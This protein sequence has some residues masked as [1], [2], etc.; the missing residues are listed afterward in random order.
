MNRTPKAAARGFFLDLALGYRAWRRAAEAAPPKPKSERRSI[1]AR[2]AARTKARNKA[3]ADDAHGR[4]MP[5][6]Q[7][8][9]WVALNIWGPS[10]RK[11]R[12]RLLSRMWTRAGHDPGIFRECVRVY[13][14][15]LAEDMDALD[16]DRKYVNSKADLAWVEYVEAAMGAPDAK[17]CEVALATINQGGTRLKDFPALHYVRA[18]SG[19]YKNGVVHVRRGK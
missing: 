9:L 3:A 19:S 16:D 15:A 6:V 18:P 8:D 14:G 13:L 2:K 7:G 5:Q 12:A 17:A 10:G 4:H 11:N 1:A